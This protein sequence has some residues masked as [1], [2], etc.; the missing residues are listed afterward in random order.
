MEMLSEGYLRR[1]RT[2]SERQTP[3]HILTCNPDLNPGSFWRRNRG[4]AASSTKTGK[5]GNS[6]G[7]APATYIS[8]KS[9]Y[10]KILTRVHASRADCL[11]TTVEVLQLSTGKWRRVE[12][13]QPPKRTGGAESKRQR[14]EVG[15]AD[16]KAGAKRA[17]DGEPGGGAGGS[18][19]AR[20]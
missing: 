14:M 20:N 12:G 11:H 5:V 15:T 2:P 10:D 1:L 19:D 8:F 9:F 4:S 18:V 3:R 16:R 13:I 7:S 6:N 17:R